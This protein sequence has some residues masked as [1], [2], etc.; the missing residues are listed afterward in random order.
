MYLVKK[1]H[2]L[3]KLSRLKLW[4]KG[5]LNGIAATIE[6]EN[7]ISSINPETIID[8][9]SNKGQFILLVEQLF[10]N[11]II[12]SFE[13]L[14]EIL[15]I[16]R[17]F[18]NRNKNIFFYNFALGSSSSIRKFFITRR[19]DSSSFLK[20]SENKNKSKYYE[21][22]TEKNIQI[23]SLDE[24]VIN[25]EIK[26]PILMKIDVQGYELEVLKGS[27]NILKKVEYILIEVSENEMYKDQPLSNEI[28]NFLQNR[29][30][31]ILK[32][33]HP[34]KISKTN[35]I[36]KDILFQNQSIKAR[37]G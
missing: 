14:T 24:V 22:N 31:Q 12:H 20:I 18:F 10:P 26:K 34:I 23:K 3:F 17:K 15:E 11:K 7:M 35:F 8:I 13:P 29:N 2:K 25:W 28:I 19:K 21:I 32:Q 16:Q 4:R 9:G 6:L 37:A 27:E 1:I 5:L 36:Q 30:Y 33:N